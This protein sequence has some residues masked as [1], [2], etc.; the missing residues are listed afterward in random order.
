MPSPAPPSSPFPVPATPPTGATPRKLAAPHRR[1]RA[2]C[3]SGIALSVGLATGAAIAGPVSVPDFTPPAAPAGDL[4]PALQ[5]P[6]DSQPDALAAG[7]AVAVHRVAIRGNSVLPAA[8]LDTIAADYRGRELTL[9][10]LYALRDALTAAYQAAGY[11]SSGALLDEP[12]I[13]AGVVQLRI[14]EGRL[15]QIRVRSDGRFRADYFESRLRA[16]GAVVNLH[17]LEERLQ[18][19]ERDPRIASVNARLLPGESRGLADLELAVRER[20]PWRAEL[21]LAND[22]SPSVGSETLQLRASHLN[23][24]GV[25]DRFDAAL[26]A[27][28]GLAEVSLDYARPLAADDRS[29]AVYLRGSRSEVVDA[30]FA[31]LQIESRSAT[32]GARFGLPLR[33]AGGER[34]DLSLATEYRRS[35]AFLLGT[36]FSFSPGPEQGVAKIAALRLSLDWS[37]RGAGRALSASS[38]LSLGLDALGATAHPGDAP[39]GQFLAWLG[40]I[41]W[42]ERLDWLDSTLVVRGDLQ[43]SDS[44][45]LGMEQFAIG[46]AASL[47]GY[48]ENTLLRDEG[49]LASLEWRVPLPT[50]AAGHWQIA[51]FVDAGYGRRRARPNSGPRDLSSVG[52][53]LYWRAGESFSARLALAHALRDIEA[54]GEEDV[55]DE[56]VHFA[57][58]TSWP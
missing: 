56:G 2:A 25:G 52:L 11:V 44:A 50:E 4:L 30:V 43:L 6:L 36:G 8:R 14:V 57:L 1:L 23:P 5:I 46:G 18:R 22:A 37:R 40:R 53:A 9:G 34:L 13:I 32:V 54:Q 48:R 28:Q 3:L 31:P 15:D 29:L 26:R 20:P 21:R 51:P 45:L 38:R 12:P 17:A 7:L 49:A 24:A 10:D 16:S 27:A 19:F 58:Q 47:R 39:D 41:Q 33:R 55:Q 35:D 42:A